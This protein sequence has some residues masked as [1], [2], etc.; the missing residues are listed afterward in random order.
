MMG[1]SINSG[2]SG[3]LQSLLS[4]ES[5]HH[6]AELLAR[7]LLVPPAARVDQETAVYVV[8]RHS[9]GPFAGVGESHGNASSTCSSGGMPS[10]SGGCCLLSHFVWL[11]S[12]TDTRL[13]QSDACTD[14]ATS[15][16]KGLL[17]ISFSFSNRSMA[18]A[19]SGFWASS[20]SA[21][22]PDMAY[23]LMIWS[24]GWGSTISPLY[25]STS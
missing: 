18:S 21:A 2:I 22:M 4:P 17:P 14:L 13:F 19:G 11:S 3:L 7:E 9:P 5:L 1:Y 20:Q 24:S 12:T 25:S 16:P 10:G 6:A 8:P 15:V 23:S